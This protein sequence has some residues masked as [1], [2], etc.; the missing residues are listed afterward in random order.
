MIFR[1]L[2]LI[3]TLRKRNETIEHTWNN[4]KIKIN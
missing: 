4:Q 1:L 2:K 3:K